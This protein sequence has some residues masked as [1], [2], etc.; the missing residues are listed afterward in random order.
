MLIISNIGDHVWL[1]TSRQ[2][3]PDLQRGSLD[4][5]CRRG[6]DAQLINVGVENPVDEADAWRLVGVLIGELD[7][8]FPD[9]ALEW[10]CYLSTAFSE[11]V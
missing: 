3:E 11:C 10:C 1:I 8:N 6:R 2:T 5:F 7:V 4:L 9:P